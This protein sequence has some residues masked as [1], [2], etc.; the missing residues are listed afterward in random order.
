M[1]QSK[2][3]QLSVL[4]YNQMYAG[5]GSFF[6]FLRIHFWHNLGKP[7]I[8]K[9]HGDIKR[10]LKVIKE[11]NPD[12]LGLTEI[13]GSWQEKEF[14]TALKKLGYKSFHVGHGH[15]W[16]HTKERVTAMIATK[17]PSKQIA[18]RLKIYA[19][20]LPGMGGG[21]GIVQAYIPKINTHVMLVHFAVSWGNALRKRI[22]EEQIQTVRKFIRQ[23]K[24]R[25]FLVMGDFNMEYD[26]IQKLLKPSNFLRLSG[27]EPTCNFSGPMRHIY[28]KS[29]DHILGNGFEPI[30]HGTIL[31][32]SDHKGVWAVLGKLQPTQQSRVK[33]VYSSGT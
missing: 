18:V 25:K 30:D 19:S 2:K 4:T 33:N 12:I 8:M 21:G 16:P 22:L 17:M 15:G 9:K 7:Q 28:C 14:R 13:L 29:I 27:N 20:T 31:G 24:N 6:G 26:D 23:N 11:I 5:N 32:H 1:R 10:T 3:N